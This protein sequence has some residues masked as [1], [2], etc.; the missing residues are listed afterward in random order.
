MPASTTAK[1]MR[2]YKP[3]L[4]GT[5]LDDVMT[6]EGR[7]RRDAARQAVADAE[8]QPRLE[9]IYESLSTVGKKRGGTVSASKRGDG[10]AQRGKT[11]GKFI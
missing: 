3:R 2:G 5:T 4:P 8:M 10:I 9:E 1:G 6:E 11:R 7:A